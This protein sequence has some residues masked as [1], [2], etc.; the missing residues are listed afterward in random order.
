MQTACMEQG[1]SRKG[2]WTMHLGRGMLGNGGSQSKGQHTMKDIL[3]VRSR[4]RRHCR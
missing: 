4:R 1:A 3:H 2:G